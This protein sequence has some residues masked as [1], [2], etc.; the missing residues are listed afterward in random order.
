MGREAG[1]GA[2][3][4]VRGAIESETVA[5]EDCGNGLQLVE[6]RGCRRGEEEEKK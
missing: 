6:K 3:C 1:F 2:D 4:G 5:E